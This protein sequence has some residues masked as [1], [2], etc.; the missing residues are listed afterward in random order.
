M[1][2]R[3]VGTAA[4]LALSLNFSYI[5]ATALPAQAGCGGSTDGSPPV[6]SSPL[7][8]ESPVPAGGVIG[9][10]IT[11]ADQDGLCEAQLQLDGAEWVGMSIDGTLLG[12]SFTAPDAS[13]GHDICFRAVDAG[14]TATDGATC[15]AFDTVASKAI[16][17]T[18]TGSGTGNVNSDPP[19]L[20]C[21]SSCSDRLP[22]G[23]PITLEARTESGHF[24]GWDSC[25]DVGVLSC[26]LSLDSDTEIG[27][28]FSEDTGVGDGRIYFGADTG[29]PSDDPNAWCHILPVVASAD[30]DGSSRKDVSHWEDYPLPECSAGLNYYPGALALGGGTPFSPD[31][32]LVAY[33]SY[34]A[35]SRLGHFSSVWIADPDGNDRRELSPSPYSYSARP[36]GFS[37]DGEWV[38]AETNE[39]LRAF[40]VDGSGSMKLTGFPS[41]SWWTDRDAIYGEWSAIFSPAASQIAFA[42]E[43]HPGSLCRQY[44]VWTMDVDLQAGTAANPRRLMAGDP[45]L[46]LRTAPMSWSSD[47]RTLLVNRYTDVRYA[48]EV[49]ESCPGHS[50]LPSHQIVAVD[51]ETDTS[52]VLLE[53]ADVVGTRDEY[54]CA[55][56]S[57][58]GAKIAY[59]RGTGMDANW[60]VDLVSGASYQFGA[61]G[62]QCPAWQPITDPLVPPGG[63]F[64][65]GD[66]LTLYNHQPE[67]S[68]QDI[69]I[70]DTSGFDLFDATLQPAE[71]EY[72]EYPVAGTFTYD[73]SDGLESNSF[74]G[75]APMAEVSADPL[76]TMALSQK[77]TSYATAYATT[78]VVLTWAHSRPTNVI[79][80]VQQMPL[81]GSTWSDLLVGTEDL[82]GSFS[83]GQG[84]SLYRTRSRTEAATSGWSP[85]VACDRVEGCRVVDPAALGVRVVH[86]VSI[87]LHGVGSG[88]VESDEGSL[89][90]EA[91]CA[92]LVP[93]G[94]TLVLTARAEA[95]S[96]FLGWDGDCAGS[97]PTCTLLVED[98]SAVEVTFGT[99][100][101]ACDSS[102]PLRDGSHERITC[103]WTNATPR[104]TLV[105]LTAGSMVL[106]TKVFS[107]KGSLRK[108][109]PVG[110][111]SVNVFVGSSRGASTY[112]A[113]SGSGL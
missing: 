73:N 63:D 40:R 41:P 93:E 54:N 71:G 25:P 59:S 34:G 8:E 31:G 39:W 78:S 11:A 1:G 26:S 29:Y 6:L 91:D 87:T 81:G 21:S 32:S 109:V 57:P 60:I 53:S 77:T 16:D 27:V 2:L 67:A 88:T 4:T 33:S 62:E 66:D 55:T 105:R 56:L 64:V 79:F 45:F 82:S 101:F 95:G 112:L 68:A 17:L 30:P 70:Q 61:A 94:R 65:L 110:S 37:A 102:G 51:V 69:Q 107:A 100:T 23:S 83:Q 89:L 18:L 24:A 36:T 15:L 12:G 46:T 86:P 113:F 104:T 43:S 76:A 13:T 44:Q 38:L 103:V 9:V 42:V 49:P 19:G 97:M 96:V 28:A 7:L 35:G 48:E 74:V 80:D 22:A 90:C 99:G 52:T 111:W 92:A 14:G 75:V 20:T 108:R 58:S 85:V 47:G 5:V 10:R 50:M 72:F 3:R 98:A 84:V 106:E